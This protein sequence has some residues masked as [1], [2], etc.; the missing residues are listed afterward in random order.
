VEEQNEYVPVYSC[1]VVE[2]DTP[3]HAMESEK[4]FNSK[5][6]DGWELFDITTYPPD[7]SGKI[8]ERYTFRNRPG[9]TPKS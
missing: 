8:F 2:F 5:V 7:S 3:R 1:V 4:L 6:T 9:F